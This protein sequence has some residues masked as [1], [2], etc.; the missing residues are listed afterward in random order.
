M[1]DSEPDSEESDHHS[2][3]DESDHSSDDNF[4]GKFDLFLCLCVFT[5]KHVAGQSGR[6][7]VFPCTVVLTLDPIPSEAD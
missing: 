5:S 2:T 4:D 7:F 6:H 3:S 1:S